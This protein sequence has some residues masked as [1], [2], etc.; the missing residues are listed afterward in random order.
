M[1]WVDWQNA[2]QVLLDFVQ[3]LISVRKAHPVLRQGRFLHGNRHQADV[4]RDISWRMPDGS[5]PSDND[6][7]DPDWKTLC[8]VFRSQL[9][10][11]RYDLSDDEIFA[12]FN[13]ANRTEVVLPDSPKGRYW[14]KIIDTAKPNLAQTPL[15]LKI[16]EVAPHSVQAFSLETVA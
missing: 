7:N 16:V 10:S 5:D 3:N 8:V 11:P 1:G 12:V 13:N 4:K 14:V 15:H 9:D 6:W 2:D